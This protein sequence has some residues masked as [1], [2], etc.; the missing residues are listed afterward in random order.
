MQEFV[1]VKKILI[2][3]SFSVILQRRLRVKCMIFCTS[4]LGVVFG[5][6]SSE[7]FD[8]KHALIFVA[9]VMFVFIIL[10]LLARRIFAPLLSFVLLF[11]ISFF[12]ADNK[13][14]KESS[15]F[16]QFTDKE[17]IISGKIIDL[18]AK[19]SDNFSYTVLIEQ[20]L[21]DNK[22]HNIKEKI[23]L[24]T[25]SELNYGDVVKAKGKIKKIPENTNENSFNSLMYYKS[26]GINRKIYS[27]ECEKCNI[28]ANTYDLYS[29]TTSV[30]SEIYKTI[31][32][33]YD[34][35]DAALLSAIA[36]G[37]KH[38]FSKEF[39]ELITKTGV[40]RCVYPVFLQITL[41]I[42]LMS[43]LKGIVPHKYRLVALSVF[44]L[45]LGTANS[46]N[47]IFVKSALF[48]GLFN[49]SKQLFGFS[50]KQDWILITIISML[51]A[52]PLLLYNGGFITS[53]TANV[54]IIFFMEFVYPKLRFLYFKHLRRIV[55]TSLIC[56][57]G[58][59]PLVAYYFNGFSL[60]QLPVSFFIFP[61]TI[62][63]FLLSPILVIM[64]K[65]FGCAPLLSNIINLLLYIYKSVP[66]FIEKL[67]YH[68]ISLPT[69]SVLSIIAFYLLVYA[70]YLYLDKRFYYVPLITGLFIYSGIIISQIASSYTAQITFINVGQGDA[71]LIS[72]PHRCNIIIDGGGGYELTKD[73][74]DINT[75]NVGEEVFIPYLQTHGKTEIDAA[76][77]SH[78]HKDHVEGILAAVENLYVKNIYMPDLLPENEW[79]RK[80]EKAAIG[81]GIEIHYIKENR[82][83]RFED[84][85]IIEMI[86][87][88]LTA[89]L[90]NEENN[91]TVVYKVIYGKTSTLFT[92]DMTALYEASL[93]YKGV[94]LNSDILKVA[95][96]GSATSTTIEFVKAVSPDY[97]VISTEEGNP[98][99]FPRKEVINNLTGIKLY[100]T[101][102]NGDIRFTIDRNGIKSI[103]TLK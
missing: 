80:I 25:K 51:L 72:I 33:F 5:I 59:I 89:L 52:N 54:L 15:D 102:I 10:S 88:T 71:A 58:L 91:T 6:I 45:F 93:I 24:T 43:L 3:H 48:I 81:K 99:G 50:L 31:N 27:E 32:R 34:G 84:G 77:I 49:L 75:Y 26:K 90:S 98:Y 13:L 74:K 86:F 100:R 94:N 30:R 47:P 78:Y 76:F 85:I 4:L 61:L 28:K 67:P 56:T 38:T 95:H 70:F 46:T 83:I 44:L 9:S 73:E 20:V 40:K 16:V 101:D 57:I 96:H 39:N 42:T 68:Y 12:L 62:I 82:R 19:N 22:A 66:Y 103:D 17:V 53:I 11:S 14:N 35:D 79:R 55:A 92:G 2:F 37:N 41:F 36:I 7:Y 87:P 63:I 1:F 23:R 18:P 65:L 64:L 8:I 97:A 69:P 21:C 29:L 60:Y